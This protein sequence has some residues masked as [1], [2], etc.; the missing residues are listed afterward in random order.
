MDSTP[1]TE[2]ASF[3]S[4]P[5]PDVIVS[6]CNA[7]SSSLSSSDSLTVRTNAATYLELDVPKKLSKLLTTP[8]DESGLIGGKAINPVWKSRVQY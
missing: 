2:V 6:A 4:N 5:R 7:I 8:Y 1:L 3:L